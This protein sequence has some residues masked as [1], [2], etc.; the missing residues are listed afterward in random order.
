M[1]LDTYSIPPIQLRHQF[2]THNSIEAFNGYFEMVPALSDELK[3]EVYKLRYQVFCIE[4]TFENP[5]HYPDNL[6]FDEFDKHSV[7]YLIR[8]RKSGDYAA[9]VRLILPD[10]HNPEKLFPLEKHCKINNIAVMQPINRRHLAEISRLC[11]SKSFKKRKN[12]THTLASIDSDWQ[13]AFTPKECLTFPMISI[14]LMACCIKASHE[15]DIFYTY[16]TMEP[17]WLRFISALSINLIK[18][19]PLVDYHGKRWP[20]LIKGTEMLDCLAEK[21]PDM[22]NFF[23][24][25][26]RFIKRSIKN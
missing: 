23:T 4:N 7:H 20:T 24:N 19:G 13:I 26:G 14:A 9:T 2:L 16:G 17:S 1:K 12:A 10:A 22:W 25:K 5:D 3:N 11:V 6:E 15:N 21:N 8:H 18:I